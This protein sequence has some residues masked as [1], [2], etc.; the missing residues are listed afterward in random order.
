[1]AFIKFNTGDLLQLKKKHP[2]GS[3]LFRVARGGTDVKII[4]EGCGRELTLERES[5][6]KTIRKVM[7]KS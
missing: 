1:M 4:C 2:C 5:L 6:E 3:L 7:Q